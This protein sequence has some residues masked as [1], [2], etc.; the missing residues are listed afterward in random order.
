LEKAKKLQSY[1]TNSW[2]HQVDVNKIGNLGQF[3]ELFCY[4]KVSGSSFKA[5]GSE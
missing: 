5:D 2:E 1:A 3:Y 4:L